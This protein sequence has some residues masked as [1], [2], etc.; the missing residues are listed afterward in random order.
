MYAK[1]QQ[2]RKQSKDAEMR[3]L[4]EAAEI[5]E[6]S[7]VLCNHLSNADILKTLEDVFRFYSDCEALRSKRRKLV[8]SIIQAL[9]RAN[10]SIRDADL[11][12]NRIIADIPTYSKQCLVKL[13]NFCLASINDYEDHVRSWK[14]LLPVLLEALE[15]EKYINCDDA[16][17]SGMEYKSTIVK[18]LCDGRWKG[19]VLPSLAKMFGDITLEKNDRNIVIRA[20][21]DMLS[22]LAPQ[23]VPPFVHYALRLCTREHVRCL[24]EALCKYFAYRYSHTTTSQ[25]DDNSF[26]GIDAIS[27]KEVQ[28]AESTV[29]YHIYHAARSNHESM[30]HYMRY[31]RSI[32]SAAEYMLEPFVMAI[33]LSV[34]SIYDN[35][36][37]EILKLAI[38]HAVEDEQR[39]KNDAWLKLIVPQT[40]GIMDIMD[41]IIENS[42][43]DRHLV[44]Q[45][46]MNLAFVLMDQKSKNSSSAFCELGVKMLQRLVRKRREMVVVV[47][48]LLIEKIMGSGIVVS[49]Y[50]ECL[51]Y[52]CR[53]LTSIVFDC[54]VWIMS[55]LDQLPVIP[56]VAAIQILH[57]IFPLM[58]VSSSIRENLI[59][60]LRKAL[61]RKDTLKRRMAVSGFLE[62]LKFFKTNSSFPF[63]ASQSRSSTMRYTGSSSTSTLTQVALERSIRQSNSTSEYKKTLCNEILCILKKCFS[64]EY[65]IRIHLYRGLYE[66]T[67]KN[68]G[69][70]DSVLDMLLSHFNLYYEPDENIL[71]PIRLDSCME[72]H[73]TDV[74]LQEPIAE[75]LFAMQNI[76]F[77]TAPRKST[78]AQRVFQLLESLCVRMEATEM[79]HLNLNVKPT[80]L[81]EGSSK[82]QQKL[83]SVKTIIKIYES[84]M[85]FRIGTWSTDKRTV[86]RNIKD[87]FKGYNG[88]VEIS[89]HTF[90]VK[91]TDNK[92]KKN[93][94]D[95]NTVGRVKPVK[96]GDTKLP[97]TVMDLDA[98]H[99]ALSL[100][101]LLKAS[102]GVNEGEVT[103]FQECPDFHRY[104]LHTTQNLL[105]KARSWKSEEN[106]GQECPF[107]DTCFHLG[108]LLYKYPV[109]NLME[110]FQVEELEAVLP[111]ECFK[112]FCQLMWTRWP[113][114]L[115]GF[116]ENCAA[117]LA[118]TEAEDNDRRLHRVLSS[119]QNILETSVDASPND[120][121]KLNA[122]RLILLEILDRLTQ[123][124]DFGKPEIYQVF[125][126][127]KKFARTG[128]MGRA[129]SKALLQ[130]LL[131]VEERC[132]EY[133]E[134]L[135][136]I[137]EEL[138]GVLGCIDGTEATVPG[139]YKVV[140]PEAAEQT[141]NTLNWYIKEKLN[142]ASWAM[143]R[144]K[145]EDTVSRTSAGPS[146]SAITGRDCLRDKERSLCRQLSYV[147][148]T[149][150]TLANIKI[151]PGQ[152]T[153]IMF[154]NLQYLYHL[155][156]TLTKYFCAKSSN[157]CPA[158]EA[159][160]FI[161]VV[162]LAGNPLKSTFYN[163][164]IHVEEN[165]HR[166]VSRLDS[167]AQ[168]TK[169]LKQTKVIPRVVYE[170]EQFHKEI[171][172]LE[173]K[174]GVPL[175]NYTKHS[176]TRDFRIKTPQLV[177]DIEKMDI[178]VLISQRSPHPLDDENGADSATHDAR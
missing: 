75:L 9:G 109:S 138:C 30:R 74:I 111:L 157:Q 60:T 150:Q 47:L 62:L 51:G 99:R 44:L 17:I 172:L 4:V 34:S 58:R 171:L 119:L 92:P 168:R 125:E 15:E 127:L 68:P 80:D 69:L 137:C 114:R 167:R 113:S 115:A 110:D 43:S 56:G 87:I 177:E 67:I 151:D 81:E 105:Q 101:Y 16:E 59:L 36:V 173:K 13:V 39:R 50:A 1:L 158:F 42:D 149:M 55:L 165:Q 70:A 83:A 164:I 35:Q 24:F 142:N 139:A 174:T 78:T 134:T 97:D 178:S 33:L 52:M 129:C 23:E 93:V 104:V 170:I 7:E 85:A 2:L 21:C 54:E 122:V 84:L 25:V 91:K 135:N 140:S 48:Q 40:R 45:G 108:E 22:D 3:R 161:Q 107:V 65:E 103:V 106:V 19:I 144:L 95:G 120:D 37:F 156:G 10:V 148:R 20:L 57:A 18:T 128:G 154:K 49:H 86:L 12:I 72:M 131:Q 53:K 102:S 14:D 162:Q 46:L 155:V 26:E 146:D 124:L 166:F 31:L 38:E 64:Y 77:Y 123:E 163:L 116:I 169:V 5:E 153:D 159:V 117:T 175:E 94:V 118:E 32:V 82:Q 29:L 88:F 89:K 66:M 73:G 136:E 76:Y 98:M 112:E 176:V 132:R 79:E 133:G 27:I 141:Y 152:C 61:Y 6:L 126:W 11:I 121:V 143:S 28:N 100:A 147:I 90:K 8:E 130:L 160:R 63:T 41:Q 145:A 96:S 71:P